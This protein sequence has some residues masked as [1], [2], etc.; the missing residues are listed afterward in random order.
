MEQPDPNGLFEMKNQSIEC[1]TFFKCFMHEKCKKMYYCEPCLFLMDGL[2]PILDYVEFTALIFDA[3]GT[4]GIIYV[5][6]DNVGVGVD[7]WFNDDDHESCIDGENE[8]NICELRN[9]D[10]EFDEDVVIMNRTSND[11]FLSGQ[12]QANSMVEDGQ[13]LVNVVVEEDVEVHNV[14]V[15]QVRPIS[16][17]LKGIVRR[18][19]REY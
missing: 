14:Q 8:D 17:I 10:V 5:Y 3:Y 7:G 1:V 11:P 18:S 12:G 9:V 13:G 16:N 19:L 6:I 4:D 15:Q 2:N